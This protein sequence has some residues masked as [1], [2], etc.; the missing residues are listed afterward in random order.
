VTTERRKPVSLLAVCALACLLSGACIVIPHRGKIRGP[1][2]SAGSVDLRF[3][4]SG[5]T[6]RDEV[7]ERLTLIDVGVAD[8]ALFWGRWRREWDVYWLAAGGGQ[9]AAVA[10]GGKASLWRRRNLLVEFDSSGRV[11]AFRAVGDD[12][13]LRALAEAVQRMR[14]PN[15][16]AG[17]ELSLVSQA[18]ERIVLGNGQVSFGGLLSGDPRFECEFGR[19]TAL[20][21]KA[22][23]E[24]VRIFLSLRSSIPGSMGR[25]VRRDFGLRARQL[26]QLVEFF[27]ANGLHRILAGSAGTPSDRRN[28]AQHD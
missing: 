4:Q 27:E 7:R 12:E 9:T 1:A 17:A 20:D 19:L 8:D 24:E 14:P 22:E 23:S 16:P 18:G 15:R 3:L 21:V 5:V 11:A 26:Y 2:G 25:K 10:G 13:L 28:S 6:T